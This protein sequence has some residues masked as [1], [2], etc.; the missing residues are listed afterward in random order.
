ME[1]KNRMSDFFRNGRKKRTSRIFGRT[2][3]RLIQ[4]RNREN[5]T[6]ICLII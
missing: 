1:G 6:W 5:R 2:D 4:N 3:K